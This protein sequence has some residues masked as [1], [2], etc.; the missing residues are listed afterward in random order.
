ML[1]T[2]LLVG[3]LATVSAGAQAD[4]TRIEIRMPPGAAAPDEQ[5]I[6]KALLPRPVEGEKR[7]LRVTVRSEDGGQTMR[8]DIW[9]AVAPD[10][11]ATLRQ[12]FP[13]LQTAA[14]AVSALE[15]PPPAVAG[16][17]DGDLSDPDTV[18]ALKKK[19]EERLRAEG[20]DGTVE[21]EVDDADG[22]RNVEVRVK[23]TKKP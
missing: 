14:I 2:A 1:R 4:G 16:L 18:A 15:G 9:G 21:V 3:L 7:Q 11:Q 8:L 13:A 23:T 22:R 17:P 5:Q 6:L 20:K 19:I 10:I 12:A